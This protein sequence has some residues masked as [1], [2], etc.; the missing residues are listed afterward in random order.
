MATS[1]IIDSLLSGDTKSLA[2]AITW[3]ENDD[4]RANEVLESAF[5]RGRNIP[6]I[7]ITGPAGEG[8]EFTHRCVNSTLS[9]RRKKSRNRG[10][11][12]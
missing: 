1:Q 11:R 6:I 5:P 12:S 3:V 4:P 7:G 8:E 2:R 9:H 10:C